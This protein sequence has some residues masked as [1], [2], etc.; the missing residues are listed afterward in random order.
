MLLTQRE[1]DLTT[2]NEYILEAFGRAF[3]GEFVSLTPTLYNALR[4]DS[5]YHRI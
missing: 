5:I 2:E 3:E 1:R 4:V